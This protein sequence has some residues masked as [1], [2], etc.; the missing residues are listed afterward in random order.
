MKKSCLADEFFLSANTTSGFYSLYNNLYDPLDGWFCYI[1][2]GGPGTGKSTL[3]KKIAKKALE[4]GEKAEIIRCSSAPYSLDAVILPNLKKAVV[5]GTAPHTMDPIFPAVSDTVINLCD[6][7]N[8]KILKKSKNSIL[9]LYAQNSSLHKK[10]QTY[11]KAHKILDSQNKYIF[12]KSIDFKALDKY[13]ETLFKKI[14]NSKSSSETLHKSSRFITSITPKGV[15]SLDKTFDLKSS[16]ILILED[17]YFLSGSYI[18]K[19]IR[20]KAIN[21]NYS[22]ISC[23]SP[24]SPENELEALFIPELDISFTVKNSKQCKEFMKNSDCECKKISLKKFINP[25]IINEH[26]NLIKFNERICGEFLDEGIKNLEK[27]LSVH[28]EIEKYYKSAMDYSKVNKI[29]DELIYA[30]L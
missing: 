28:D 2:K 23:P 12:K 18:L 16:K 5:D 24:F 25:E 27:A 22:I 6:C 10:S 26:K 21:L 30:I 19:K 13:C 11:L 1:L 4:K 3:M 29:T 20:E 9:D 7:W 15:L 8:K 14:F 17:K